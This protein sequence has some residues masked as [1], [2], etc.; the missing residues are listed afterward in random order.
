MSNDKALFEEFLIW[1]TTRENQ[2][3]SVIGPDPSHRGVIDLGFVR[4]AP[5]EFPKMVYRTS[6]KDP[7]GYT[8][9]IIES[10]EEQ[11]TAV[12]QGWLVQTKEIHALLD[13]LRPSASGE[14]GATE[15]A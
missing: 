6:G 5:S 11:A 12:K 4:P 2:R 3:K 7:K 13:G 15:A 8:P 1:K 9:R 14:A 10:A